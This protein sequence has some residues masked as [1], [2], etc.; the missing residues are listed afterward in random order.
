M[1]L[2]HK[3]HT[4][5]GMT[6]HK[7]IE[8]LTPRPSTEPRRGLPRLAHSFN[9][10]SDLIRTKTQTQ[11]TINPT[12]QNNTPY[13][14]E[15]FRKTHKMKQMMQHLVW[16]NLRHG[17]NVLGVWMSC[18]QMHLLIIYMKTNSKLDSMS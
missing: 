2:A 14:I 12:Q 8:K 1:S 17:N 3:V 10:V 11:K 5:K 7:Q 4:T 13:D 6:K 9:W 15:P 16:L 18:F